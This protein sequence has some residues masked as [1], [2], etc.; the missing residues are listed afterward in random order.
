MS[1]PRELAYFGAVTAKAAVEL[2]Q[3]DGSPLRLAVGERAEV[4]A[5]LRAAGYLLVARGKVAFYASDPR[6]GM[7]AHRFAF[8]PRPGL[9]DA[10][11]PE[12]RAPLPFRDG[13]LDQ[14]Y[15]A[16]RALPPPSPQ[17]P[18]GDVR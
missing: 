1:E 3:C 5:F 14:A 2:V 15:A 7:H 11:K 8:E 9:A 4:Y 10:K 16:R 12:T 6:S 18:I 17:G 13:R